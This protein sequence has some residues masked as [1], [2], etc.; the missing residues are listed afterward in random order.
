LISLK[1][2]GNRAIILFFVERNSAEWVTT[3]NEIDPEYGKLLKDAIKSG[4]EALAVKAKVSESG[5][6][7]YK[8]LPIKL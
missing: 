2:S 4:V 3:A 1:A 5:L 6:E 7:I 8:K